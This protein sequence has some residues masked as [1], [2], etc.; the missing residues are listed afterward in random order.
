MRCPKC[1]QTESFRSDL[2]EVNSFTADL[3]DGD[4]NNPKHDD[5][6]CC[7]IDADGATKCLECDYENATSEFLDGNEDFPVLKR[8]SF[9]TPDDSTESAEGDGHVAQSS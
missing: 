5:C 4:M 7:A 2:W 9:E 6:V 3:G 1:K 8:P